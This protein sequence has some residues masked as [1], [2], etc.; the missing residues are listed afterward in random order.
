MTRH[1]QAGHGKPSANLS[2]TSAAGG[3]VFTPP[4]DCIAAYGFDPRK[5]WP[6]MIMLCV[7]S[8]IMVARV[9]IY[10]MG[11]NWLPTLVLLAFPVV[12]LLMVG[13]ELRMRGPILLITESGLLDRRHGPD[14]VP[15]DGVAEAEIKKRPFIRGI[16]I[17]LTNGER[18]DLELALLR[19]EPMYLMQVIREHAE[20]AT[21]ELPRETSRRWW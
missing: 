17:K 9:A 4:A 11:E 20:R 1:P 13:Q 10:G 5:T 3:G 19:A 16:R 15:W 12:A 14:L 2:A 6:F 21:A 7:L 18:Y 8:A